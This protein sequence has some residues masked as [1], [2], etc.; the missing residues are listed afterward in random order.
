VYAYRGLEGYTGSL[1]WGLEA[2]SVVLAIAAM[3]LDAG[4]LSGPFTAFVYQ[5]INVAGW[6]QWTRDERRL[7]LVLAGP[8]A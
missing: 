6:F 7:Q 8:T 1:W 5:A 2:A 3:W 4:E